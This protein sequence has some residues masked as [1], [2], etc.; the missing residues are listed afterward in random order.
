MGSLTDRLDMTIVVDW[1]VKQHSNKQTRAALICSPHD[2]ILTV[3]LSSQYHTPFRLEKRSCCIRVILQQS[4]K[5]CRVVY[6]S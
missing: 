6:V 5:W 2:T 1:D 4:L 3:I